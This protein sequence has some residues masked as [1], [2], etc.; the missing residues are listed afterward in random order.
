MPALTDS[1]PVLRISIPVYKPEDEVSPEVA[2]RRVSRICE[3]DEDTEATRII[4][5]LLFLIAFFASVS[6]IFPPSY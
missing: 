6:A 3:E 5:F 4:G 2:I 1:R